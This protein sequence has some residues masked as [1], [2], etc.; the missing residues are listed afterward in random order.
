MPISTSD[1]RKVGMLWIHTDVAVLC[2]L[3]V[4]LVA[5]AEIVQYRMFFFR[6]KQFKAVRFSGPKHG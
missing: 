5:Y 6:H 4:P 2:P 1:G 3:T